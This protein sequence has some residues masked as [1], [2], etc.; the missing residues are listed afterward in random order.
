MKKIILLSLFLVPLISTAQSLER[1]IIGTAG[2]SSTNLSWTIGEPVT[3]TLTDGTIAL[4][5]GFHQGALTVTGIDKKT[6]LSYGVDVY[7]NP[8]KNTLTIETE[9]T[10]IPYQLMDING[11]V[12]KTGKIE[13]KT[14]KISFAGMPEG[15]YILQLNNRETHKIIKAV[16]N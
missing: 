13:S 10:G 11:K 1:E 12:L 4:T 6:F 2:N 15:T 7:P 3:K 9:K 14:V 16:G 8:V 5:Q